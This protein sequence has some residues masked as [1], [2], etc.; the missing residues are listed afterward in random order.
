MI[1][2]ESELR[3]GLL[4]RKLG[5]SFSPLI[6][7]FAGDY[8]YELFEVEP[9]NADDFIKNGAYDCINVTIPYKENAFRCA[10][11]LSDEAKAIGA[12]N[13]LVRRD[14]KIYG[15]NTDYF[16]FVALLNKNGIDP[17]GKNCLVLGTG[18]AAKMVVFA[19]GKLNAKSITSVSRSGEINY[20]NVYKE[21]SDTEIVINTTPVGMYPEISDSPIDISKFEQCEAVVD[22]IYNPSVTKLL[23]DAK[24]C[25]MKT[26]NGLYM[27]SAQGIKA[28]EF[29]TGRKI[30]DDVIDKVTDAVEQKTKNIVLIGMPGCGKSYIGSKVAEMLGREF[31]DIDKII[32][33]RENRPIPTI[34]EKDGEDYFRKIETA[35]TAE[36]CAKSGLVIATGGGVVTREENL[37]PVKC[38]SMVCY[39]KRPLSNL[40]TDGR[41]LSQKTPVE[42][43]FLQRKEK[44]ESWSDFCIEV[45]C[46]DDGISEDVAVECANNLIE[47]L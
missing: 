24:R 2:A 30:P 8:S 45:P 12:V 19:L 44:Y 36:F 5:H 42:V 14:G 33:E 13:T 21:C 10:D 37:F 28:G 18:G 22:I 6:H 46:S 16:G 15:Y 40:P 11:V 39:V 20:K 25:G 1:K 32:E 9:E 4:G 27:L 31:V 34:F 26:A 43:L 35:V 23:F 38:N 7:S 17:C 29:F 47:S 3:C 41:P